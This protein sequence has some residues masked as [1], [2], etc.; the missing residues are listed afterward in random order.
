MTAVT[1]WVELSSILR[2]VLGI[3]P[4]NKVILSYLVEPRIPQDKHVHKAIAEG[5]NDEMSKMKTSIQ[6]N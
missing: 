2:E 6:T 3:F 5:V 4:C 1:Y